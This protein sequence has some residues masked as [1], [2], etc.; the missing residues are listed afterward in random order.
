MKHWVDI[1]NP[2]LEKMSREELLAYLDVVSK[3]WLA[4]DGLWFLAVESEFGLD[5]AIQIDIKAWEGFT[6][7]EA[8]RLMKFLGLP[9]GG[10]LEAV[11]KALRYRLAA[12]V[13]H[14]EILDLPDGSFTFQMCGCRVQDARKR[15]GMAAFHCKPVG[16]VEYTGFAQIIDP[17]VRVECL[18]C[19]PDEMSDGRWCTW[20]F[21]LEE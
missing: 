20:R 4:H 9:K 2:V 3:N 13:N 16:M 15:K 21:S 14:Y 10:G 1:M 8:R 17:R 11:K 12:N 5:K 19:P 7:V 6:R 18:R